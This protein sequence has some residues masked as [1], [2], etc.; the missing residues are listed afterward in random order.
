MKTK[1][2]TKFPAMWVVV[3][4]NKIALRIFLDHTVRSITIDN[5]CY[6]TNKHLFM[7]RGWKYTRDHASYKDDF[8]NINARGK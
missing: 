7:E 2:E 5:N 1:S 4:Q 8:W 3:F 6:S